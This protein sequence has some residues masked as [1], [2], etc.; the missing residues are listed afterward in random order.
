MF[1]LF[2]FSIALLQVQE[3][4]RPLSFPKDQLPM[5][6]IAEVSEDGTKVIVSIKGGGEIRL[7]SYIASVPITK[8]IAKN[9]GKNELVTQYQ[10][11]RKKRL[12]YHGIEMISAGTFKDPPVYRYPRP[13]SAMYELGECK[14]TD[15]EGKTVDSDKVLRRLGGTRKPVLIVTGE[16]HIDAFYK[17]AIHPKM[18]LFVPPKAASNQQKGPLPPQIGQK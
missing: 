12:V 17:S 2:L 7:Q 6:G 1:A 14:L 9:D 8:S 3:V 10:Q 18:L 11:V 16:E 15:L 5:F 4:D 13:K